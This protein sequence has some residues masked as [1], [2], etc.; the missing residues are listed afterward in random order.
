MRLETFVD[1]MGINIIQVIERIQQQG[2]SLDQPLCPDDFFNP[3]W[4][5]KS[6]SQSTDES[7]GKHYEEPIGG[8]SGKTV[9]LDTS[10]TAGRL[11]ISYNEHTRHDTKESRS[12]NKTLR[13][14][15]N[16]HKSS[17]CCFEKI[18]P[19]I[20]HGRK[21][22][23]IY[24]DTVCNRHELKQSDSCI[25]SHTT[26]NIN[27]DDASLCTAS[28]A[29]KSEVKTTQSPVWRRPNQLRLTASKEF[30]KDSIK[31]YSDAVKILNR[32]AR[33]TFKAGRVDSSTFEEDD[34]ED[35]LLEL[36]PLHIDF[37][38]KFYT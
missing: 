20:G 33:N 19:W 17:V 35:L 5:Q 24:N 31:C 27:S 16:S 11:N 29:S 18:E 32:G 23:V 2:V 3:D 7:T 34:C 12:I 15:A 9:A 14:G 1:I 8:K 10:G 38:K 22:S 4:P 30:V 13:L 6:S 25:L 26:R 21:Q 28:S 36:L 37:Y